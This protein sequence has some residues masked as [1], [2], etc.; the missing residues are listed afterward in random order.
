MGLDGSTVARMKNPVVG[1]EFTEM[2]HFWLT[3]LAVEGT[4]ITWQSGA[5]EWELHVADIRTFRKQYSY[6]HIEGYWVQFV[7]NIG[8]K[9]AK[10]ILEE[11]KKEIKD[12]LKKGTAT[13]AKQKLAVKFMEV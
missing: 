3:V 10:D 11:W 6:D 9:E 13:E 8:K 1:D 4:K 2:Y 7:K 5:R 12:N